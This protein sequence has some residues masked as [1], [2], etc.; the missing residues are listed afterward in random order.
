MMICDK[1]FHTQLDEI[2]QYN[3]LGCLVTTMSVRGQELV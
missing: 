1:F 2:P 3:E